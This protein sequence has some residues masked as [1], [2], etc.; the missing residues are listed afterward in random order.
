MSRRWYKKIILFGVDAS[1]IN[2][3]IICELKTGRHY[4]T[5][6][7]KEKIY[8]QIF[9]RYKEYLENKG[10]GKK[11]ISRHKNNDDFC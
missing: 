3:K 1:I 5:V 10:A 7:F 2:S 8:E 9:K 11:K 6:E 4:T